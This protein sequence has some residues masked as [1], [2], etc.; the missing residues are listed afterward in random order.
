MKTGSQQG[1]LDRVDIK[2]LSYLQADGRVTNVELANRINL[3][4][5]ATHARVKRLEEE[6]FIR[7][8]VALVDQEKVGLDMTCFISV[9]LR[10]HGHPELE[11]FDSTIDSIPE[12][13]ECHQVTGEFDY[14]L[15]V[16]VRGR[17]DL[18]ELVTNRLAAI[19]GIS[20]IH[21]SMVLSAVK[22]TTML[23]LE[24]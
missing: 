18:K 16:V 9:S 17:G 22:S 14:L 20:R 4:P 1:D 7:G 3:S 21:T 11:V 8:Y 12:V 6:G 19:P 24:P 10:L 15:R 2:I 5:P 13:L 23:P